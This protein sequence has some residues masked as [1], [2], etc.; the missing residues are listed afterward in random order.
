[1]GS[2][3]K[4][5]YLVAELVSRNV[6]NWTPFIEKIYLAFM[7]DPIFLVCKLLNPLDI[8]EDTSVVANG[9]QN[10]F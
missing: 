5:F 1:M 4:Q 6:V 3:S 2:D 7:A 8:R 9:V 10:L